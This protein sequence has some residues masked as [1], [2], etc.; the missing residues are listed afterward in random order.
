MNLFPLRAF[1]F[2]HSLCYSNPSAFARGRVDD[3]LNQNQL[4]M[5]LSSDR[6]LSVRILLAAFRAVHWAKVPDR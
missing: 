3:R 1:P 2:G 6:P 5:K 4:E